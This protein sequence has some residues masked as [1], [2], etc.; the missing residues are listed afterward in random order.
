M[1][2]TIRSNKQKQG[3]NPG[4]IMML[5]L[6]IMTTFKKPFLIGKMKLYVGIR[7]IALNIL[8]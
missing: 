2:F 4:K 8:Y 5:D 1:L 6:K 3:K 7:V